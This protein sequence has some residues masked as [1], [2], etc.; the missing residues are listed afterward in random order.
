MS[1]TTTMFLTKTTGLDTVGLPDK[2]S[3]TIAFAPVLVPFAVVLIF[4][5]TTHCR[6]LRLIDDVHGMAELLL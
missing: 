6:T 3:K 5:V 4:E 1:H 2:A